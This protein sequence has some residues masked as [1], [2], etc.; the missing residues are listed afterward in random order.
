MAMRRSGGLFPQIVKTAYR[1]G[2]AVYTTY[3]RS[4]FLPSGV[5]GGGSV[6]HKDVSAISK[7]MLAPAGARIASY[8]SATSAVTRV[9]Q[10]AAPGNATIVGRA[11]SSDA[12]RW[13]FSYLVKSAQHVG[14]CYYE[15]S[16]A[17]LS[18]LV[19][20]TASAG[21]VMG[22]GDTIDWKGLLWTSVGTMMLAASANSL[23][24]LMEI[25]N[26]AAMKR[27]MRRPLPSG[28]IGP[29]HAFVWAAAMGLSGVALL[30][31]QT[32]DLTAGLGAA[33]VALYTLVYTPL[34][35]LHPI[36]TWVG[37]VVGAIPPLM[38]WA[39]ATNQLDPGA[40]VLAGAVYLWQ[41]PHFMALAWMCR[42][43]YAA[44]GYKM[45]SFVDKTG[46]RTAAVALRNCLYLAPLGFLAHHWGVTS[47]WF[48]AEN[49][50]LTG[51][52]A[53]AAASFYRQ[54]SAETA[55]KMFR[56][57]LVFLPLLMAS[58]LVHRSPNRA[59][60]TADLAAPAVGEASVSD[61]EY[62][63]D[64]L[65]IRAW[66]SEQQHR[67]ESQLSAARPPVAF[68]SAAPFPFL[69]PPSYGVRYY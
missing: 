49:L 18:F 31:H 39:A 23:N 54:P 26:D 61:E 42:Q 36:N 3:Q 47:A 25:K 37:A 53:L 62:E 35:Q 34:K 55:R 51:G 44:G 41:M 60:D 1:P 40:Y 58:M 38:G 10:A 46:R 11:R 17:R 2:T 32:N 20:T 24:Q 65:A 4:P 14:R 22:S 15:L 29:V 30:A 45:L 27:T 56:G 12:V 52:M 57:S 67:Q 69:P 68:I 7:S 63:K 16:K 8:F 5:N 33:N 59:H 28:R 19:V 48:A 43:D 50:V 9:A 13:S 21:F 66:S 6:V 64:L